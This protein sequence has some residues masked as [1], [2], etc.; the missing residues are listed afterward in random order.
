MVS[1]LR[2]ENL[3]VAYGRTVVFERLT[4]EFGN[5]CHAI[6]GPN[7]A[8]K[9]TLLGTVSGIVPHRGRVL[10]TGQDLVRNF[11]AARRELAYVPDAA[12]FYPFLTGKEFIDFVLRAHGLQDAKRSSRY[13]V[14]VDRLNV[15]H[16]MATPFAEASL[17]TRK[18]FFLLAAFLLASRVMVLDEPFNGLDRASAQAVVDLIRQ[19]ASTSC[20]LLTCHQP[21]FL[22]AIGGVTSWYIDRAPHHVLIPGPAYHAV[23]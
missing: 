18:K 16:Y 6:V 8:G 12:T 20:L 3:T 11:V 5:G 13:G 21:A 14:L 10:V 23:A 4:H 2:L 1:P 19:A 17:G 9:S 22:N 7:G 15:A